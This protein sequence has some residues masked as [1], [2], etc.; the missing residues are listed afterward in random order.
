VNPPRS[1]HLTPP[2]GWF[3]KDVIRHI[4]D[5]VAQKRYTKHAAGIRAHYFTL[6]EICSN[7]GGKP[8]FPATLKEIARLTHCSTRWS[9]IC[10]QDLQEIGVISRSREGRGRP[11]LWTLLALPRSPEV[12]KYVPHPGEIS[13]APVG[14]CVPPYKNKVQ[15][16][17]VRSIL[18]PPSSSGVP[19]G[20][21]PIAAHQN[22]N[23]ALPRLTDAMR[24][25]AERELDRVERAINNL[26][27]EA[28]MSEKDVLTIVE[29]LKLKQLRVRRKELKARLDLVD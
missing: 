24:V 18:V 10:L 19:T 16:K 12:G 3:N 14:N 17:G 29:R 20:T 6:C 2:A 8:T 13:S 26:E 1:R 27:P 4:Q 22:G 23:G 7:R 15:K 5:K 11:Y 9:R 28:H 21:T 25:S